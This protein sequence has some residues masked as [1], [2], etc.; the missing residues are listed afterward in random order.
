MDV[1]AG[2]SFGIDTSRFEA[3]IERMKDSIFGMESAIQDIGQQFESRGGG[4]TGPLTQ[5]MKDFDKGFAG[6]AAKAGLFGAELK[7]TEKAVF[8]AAYALN[9]DP[10]QLGENFLQLKNIGI[11]PQDLGLKDLK[12]LGMVLD[13]LGMSGEQLG[14]VFN[15][16]TGRFK[17]TKD[18]AKEFFDSFTQQTTALGIGNEAFGSLESIMASLGDKFSKTLAEEGPEAVKKTITSMV[19]LAAG[20]TKSIGGSAQENLDSAI[21]LFETLQDEANVL[22]Q[23]MAGLDADFGE[24]ASKLGVVLPGGFMQ[25]MDALKSGATD[26]LSFAKNMAQMYSEIQSKGGPQSAILLQQM[27]ALI[28]EQLGPSYQFLFEKGT[29]AVKILEQMGK[30]PEGGI[31]SLAEL[32]KQGYRTGLMIDDSLSRAKDQFEETMK[33]MVAADATKAVDQQVQAYRDLGKTMVQLKE[34]KGFEWLNQQMKRFGFSEG[35]I[36]K[37]NDTFSKFA[38]SVQLFESEGLGAALVPWTQES[39][40]LQQLVIALGEIGTILPK[41]LPLAG[42]IGGTVLAFKA[43]AGPIGFVLTPLTMLGGA[44]TSIVGSIGSAL[45]PMILTAMGPISFLGIAAVGLAGAVMAVVGAATLGTVA[46]AGWTGALEGA[47]GEKVQ[48]YTKQIQTFVTDGLYYLQDQVYALSNWLITLDVSS[49]VSDFFA[50]LFDGA[51][52]AAGKGGDSPILAAMLGMF[53]SLVDM[54]DVILEKMGDA[55]RAVPWEKLIS[56]I[57]VGI[58]KLKFWAATYDWGS[59][60]VGSTGFFASLSEVFLGLVML[61]DKIASQVDWG[62]LIATVYGAMSD[63]FWDNIGPISDNLWTI[64]KNVVSAV[65]LQIASYMGNLMKNSFKMVFGILYSFWSDAI[66]GFSNFIWDKVIKLFINMDQF[67]VDAIFGEGTFDEYF[68]DYIKSIYEFKDKVYAFIDDLLPQFYVFWDALKAGFEK[69]KWVVGEFWEAMKL[70]WKTGVALLQKAWAEPFKYF[71]RLMDTLADKLLPFY[72][73]LTRWWGSIKTGFVETW[74]SV[75]TSVTEAWTFINAYLQETWVSLQAKW[76]ELFGEEGTFRVLLRNAF[77]Y[78][79][80][81]WEAFKNTALSIGTLIRETFTNI[82]E[83]MLGVFAK[84]K[85]AIVTQFESIAST[86]ESV[87]IK[88]IGYF[89][90]NW[91]KVTDTFDVA[92]DAVSSIAKLIGLGS[93]ETPAAQAKVAS[94]VSKSDAMLIASSGDQ[95]ELV[96]MI[97]KKVDRTNDLLEQIVDKIPN[98]MGPQPKLAVITGVDGVSKSL[99]RNQ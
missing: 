48:G 80:E 29:D 16:L 30:A 56:L 27:S 4:F 85:E 38:R 66:A 44:F 39:P 37:V 62:G 91:K 60:F 61:W 35:S 8:S 11:T 87:W 58:E 65:L 10:G 36:Q 92:K 82:Q 88:I 12:E 73:A 79:Q 81:R 51:D 78:A 24:L 93:E 49:W 21:K 31:K 68:G 86:I 46:L 54:K 43:L 28:S 23:M 63:A 72:V 9:M 13:V 34:G 67:I 76:N 74:A 97:R 96:E 25:A 7:K 84:V 94:T 20:M 45:I 52:L 57:G 95:A 1:S 26:P 19:A 70:F 2:Y 47:F 15:N 41:L 90:D 42:A 6:M 50:K 64:F 98:V 18:Q 83:T 77:A 69:M 40:G 5:Q 3:G 14:G 75:K 53:D 17:F 99:P 59:L 32:G 22:P 33:A 71:E 89:L 55:I